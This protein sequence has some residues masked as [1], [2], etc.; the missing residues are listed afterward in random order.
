MEERGR[1][2]KWQGRDTNAQ[3]G[4]RKRGLEQEFGGAVVVGVRISGNGRW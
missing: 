3:N 1:E 2:E 4:E